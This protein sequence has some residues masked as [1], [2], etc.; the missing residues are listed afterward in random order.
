MTS[1]RVQETHMK[2][3]TT[4]ICF[5]LAIVLSAS[6]AFSATLVVAANNGDCTSTGATVYTTIGNAVTAASAGD[7]VLVCPGRYDEQVVITKALTLQAADSTAPLIAPTTVSANT[8]NLATGAPIAAIVLVDRTGPVIINGFAVDGSGGASTKCSPRYMGVF[9]RASAGMLQNT[10][11]TDVQ[12]TC[13]AVNFL[14]ASGVFVQSGN[15]G[16]GLNSD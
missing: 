4:L 6:S 3:T 15:G 16:P 11:V 12:D 14:H 13:A 8:T 7:T 10:S 5:A 1:R 2:T 9:F